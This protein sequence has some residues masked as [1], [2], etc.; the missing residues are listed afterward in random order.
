MSGNIYLRPTGLLYAETAMQAVKTGLAMPLAGTRIAFS[1]VEVIEGTPLKSTRELRDSRDL[2]ACTESG[3][4]DLLANLTAPRHP[5][6]GLSLDRTR[7]M[8]I[9]NI[10]PDSFSDGGEH[11]GRDVAIAHARDMVRQGADLVDIGGE[12]TRP[13]ADLISE[14]EELERVIDV[15]KT[16]ADDNIL[17]S[18]DTRRANVMRASLQAGAK[19]INDVTA[20]TFEPDSSTVVAK[21]E[22]P[23]VL[24][25][26]RGEPK[27]MQDAPY[28]DDVVLE[29]YNDLAAHIAAAEKAGI[30]RNHILIDPGIGFGKTFGHNLQLL[31]HL[32]IFH[33]L[34]AGLLVGLSRKGFIGAIT[35]VKEA[36]ERVHGSIGA[37]F[38]CI[39]QGAHVMRVHDLAATREALDAWEHAMGL[40]AHRL[41]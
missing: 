4:Q 9:V 21:A 30:D 5:I 8:G 17:V 22:C 2:A 20:L 27:T 28:F 15:I 38:S 36:G 3:I 23:V 40:S 37:A 24:M 6:A 13:G 16:L 25:H 18:A 1:N 26:I 7:L 31:E 14:A 41:P 29:V 32:S 34:G 10:T 19:I 12:S 11:E 33:G 39:T 35:G